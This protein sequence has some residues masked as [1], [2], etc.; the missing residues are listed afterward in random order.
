MREIKK[1]KKDKIKCGIFDLGKINLFTKKK[2]LKSLFVQEWIL[3]FNVEWKFTN[4][5]LGDVDLV[6][7]QWVYL[8]LNFFISKVYNSIKISI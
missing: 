3:N 8:C 1:C 4:L 7:L 2:Y 6:K 5:T